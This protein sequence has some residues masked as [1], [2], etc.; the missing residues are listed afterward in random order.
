MAALTE[1]A[2]TLAADPALRRA[3]QQEPEALAPLARPGASRGWEL[4]RTGV[5]DVLTA[6]GVATSVATVE[7][8]LRWVT[9]QLLWPAEGAAGAEVLVSGLAGEVVLAPTPTEPAV[10]G[11][12][13]LG[14]PRA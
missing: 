2:A 14:W 1:V 8:L 12:G 5:A 7:V 6:A 3:A 9:S 4:A 11:S 13:P 10:A